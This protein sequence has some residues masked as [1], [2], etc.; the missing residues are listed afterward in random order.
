M[1]KSDCLQAILSA[2]LSTSVAHSWEFARFVNIRDKNGATQLHLA[3]RQGW[4]GCVHMLLDSGALVCASSRGYVSLGLYHFILQFVG[5]HWIVFGNY[6][7]GGLIDFHRDSS[8]RIPY[9][10]ALRHKH[11]ACAALLNPSAPDPLIWPSPLKFITELNPEAKA[12]L[13]RALMETN[14]EREKTILKAIVYSLPSPLHSEAA[15]SDI[16]YEAINNQKNKLEA[17]NQGLLLNFG[18]QLDQSLKGCTRPSWGQFLN[19][20]NNGDAWRN[21]FWRKALAL[22]ADYID[23]EDSSVRIGAI[24]GLGHAYAGAQNEQIRSKLTPILGDNKVPLDVIAFTAISLA[25]VYV[26]SCNEEVAQAIIFA[27]MDRSELELGEPL[28]RL[29]PLGLGLLY[30]GKQSVEAT[31]EV[32]KTF[33]EKIRKYYDMTLLSCAYAGTGNV[34]KVQHLLGQCAQHLEKGEAHQGPAILGIAM[35]AM[36]EE[37]GLEMAIRLLEHLLQYGEQNI[38]RAVPLALGLLCI[39][40]PKVNVMDTLNRL[41]HDTDTEIAM[42]GVIS[43]G[44]IGAGTNNARIAG[45]LRNLSSY[46]YKE[47]SLLFCVRIAQGLVH[48]GKGLLTLAPY[49]SER[50]LLSPGR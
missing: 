49:H 3:A 11:A 45:M 35:V 43:L 25:L 41:S 29:L 19:N 26:G 40:N 32:S 38:R 4:P 37:L 34:L 1:I 22:L 33:N 16:M 13:E 31:A 17:E 10:V 8:G 18:S 6:L 5:V 28:T 46:Y 27:L 9:M 21:M 36:A 14:K 20:S 24:M 2:T 50:F 48:L 12:L 23:T 15:A 42:A 47:A 30:L 39:S 7:L 44:L